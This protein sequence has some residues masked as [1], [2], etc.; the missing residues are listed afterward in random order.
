MKEKKCLQKYPCEYWV[1]NGC[2]NLRFPFSDPSLQGPKLLPTLEIVT[3]AC[4]SFGAHLWGRQEKNWP[5][6]SDIRF[7]CHPFSQ[8]DE[9]FLQRFYSFWVWYCSADCAELCCALESDLPRAHFVVICQT[10]WLLAATGSLRRI[11]D[12]L[13]PTVPMD[14]NRHRQNFRPFHISLPNVL[15]CEMKSAHLALTS[16][17]AAELEKTLCRSPCPSW[18]VRKW[19]ILKWPFEFWFSSVDWMIKQHEECVLKHGLRS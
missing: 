9:I 13:I 6:Q 10:L 14:P 8:L 2:I 15:G 16:S 5:L 1:Y 12:L 17:T 18:V 4:I 11:N 7:V 3:T 19:G